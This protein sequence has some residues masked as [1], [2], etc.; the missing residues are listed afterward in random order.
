MFRSVE[1]TLFHVTINHF[2]ETNDG[3]MCNSFWANKQEI[4]SC[5]DLIDGMNL[6]SFIMQVTGI[7]LYNACF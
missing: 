1:I 5:L 7:Q 4:V 2:N 6:L 3:G